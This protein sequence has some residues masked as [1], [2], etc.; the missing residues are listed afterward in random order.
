MNNHK[1][2]QQQTTSFLPS[3]FDL[4]LFVKQLLG[5]TKFSCCLQK[6]NLELASQILASDPDV[7]LKWLDGDN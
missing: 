6:D 2:E 5:R 7:S 1:K 3:F 4:T